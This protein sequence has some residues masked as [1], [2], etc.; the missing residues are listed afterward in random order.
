VFFQQNAV[1]S[2][3]GSYN[4]KRY[5]QAAKNHAVFAIPSDVKEL[6][7]NEDRNALK[8][9]REMLAKG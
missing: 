7:S 2:S 3:D 1:G 4:G 8:L 5:F 6:L 9:R